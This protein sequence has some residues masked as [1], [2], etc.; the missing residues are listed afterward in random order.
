MTDDPAA[1]RAEIARLRG[2]LDYHDIDPDPALPEPPAV[3][4]SHLR[5]MAFSAHDGAS[6]GRCGQAAGRPDR[7]KGVL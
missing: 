3:L 7:G 5:R 2:L 4:G 1:L 6:Y